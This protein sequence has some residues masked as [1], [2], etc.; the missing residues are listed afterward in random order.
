MLTYAVVNIWPTKRYKTIKPKTYRKSN[1][2]TKCGNSTPSIHEP[3]YGDMA[4]YFYIQN[5]T[6]TRCLGMAWD[7]NNNYWCSRAPSDTLSVV[8]W[9]PRLG[10]TLNIDQAE[11]GPRGGV[12]LRGRNWSV[13]CHRGLP[14]PSQPASR[15]RDPQPLKL[16]SWHL[17]CARTVTNQLLLPSDVCKSLFFTK[18][19]RVSLPSVRG[20][21]RVLVFSPGPLCYP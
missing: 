5:A 6:L 8:Y 11:A 20:L 2:S 21:R 12:S 9:L 10:R 15:E 7:I 19:Q 13:T 16:S 3:I 18:Q 1:L 14:A 17:L 4:E